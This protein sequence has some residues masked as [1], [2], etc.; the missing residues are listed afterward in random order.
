MNRAEAVAEW[1][2]DRPGLAAQGL[3][4]PGV[5]M[6]LPDE[7][8]ESEA[9]IA[10]I[11]MDAAGTL[12]TDPNSALPT[13]LTTTID[14]DVIRVVF[15]PLQMAK[16]LGDERKVGSWVDKQRIF[17][18]VEDFGEVSSYGDYANNGIVGVNFNYPWFQSYLFQTMLYYGELETDIAGLMNINY[19]GDLGRSAANILNRFGNLT[20]AFGVQNLQN[21]GL[22]NNPFLSSYIT[23]AVKA[24]GGTSWFNGGSPAATPNE[25]YNDILALIERLILQGNGVI[26]QDSPMVLAFSPGSNVAVGF[27][28]SFGVF[29]RTLLKEGYPNL[30][31]RTAP[32]YGTQTIQNNQGYS[33]VGNLMQ[34]I[35][36]QVDGQQVGYCAFNEKLRAHKIIPKASSWEQKMTSGTWGTI[37]RVPL[38]IVGMLG[39]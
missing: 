11:A 16:I 1:N 17:P 19:V 22:L 20:Y 14:P 32:Q 27:A 36:T 15:A 26:D 5:T 8:K 24:W 30:T 21:Y 38:G 4:L 28:N 7:W 37:I 9:S 23:P 6:Y 12:S 10:Q 3:I 31:I 13:M 34:L 25:V 18:V 33:T 29:V 35:A 2:R 39:I